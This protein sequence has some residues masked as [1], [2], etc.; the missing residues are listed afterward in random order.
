MTGD[1]ELTSY[2]SI[3]I[4]SYLKH[5][6]RPDSWNNL[7]ERPYLISKLPGLK[8][9]DVLDTGCG[10]GFYTDYALG[11]GAKVTAV[12]ISQKMVGFIASRIKSTNLTLHCTDISKPMPFLPDDSY[13][14]AICS[15][16]LH[17]IRDWQILFQ[18]LF[19][20]L[21]DG[22][23]VYITTHNPLAMYLYLQP[24]SYYDFR[25]VQDTWGTPENRFKVRYYIRP[26]TEILK[27]VIQ[28]KFKV[29]SIEEMLPDERLKESH[30]EIYDRLSKQPGFLY[31]E[32]VKEGG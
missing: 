31:V 5:I 10:S 13:D 19:R 2:D 26:L 9:K 24:D 25:L 17:Y 7:Y 1:A 15:L 30:P 18:E 6:E 27:P 14:I 32:M 3:D 12:D 21:R 23:K 28:S 11:A 4:D 16:V 8:D 22:G 29:E 20:V